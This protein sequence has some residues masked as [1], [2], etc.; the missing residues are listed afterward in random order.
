MNRYFVL[1]DLQAMHAAGTDDAVGHSMLGQSARL[2]IIQV[3]T[4]GAIYF[5]NQFA[6]LIKRQ[7]LKSGHFAIA[8]A[9]VARAAGDRFPF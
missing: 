8:I 5:R 1:L 2:P 4:S 6:R 3:R 7:C 9:H